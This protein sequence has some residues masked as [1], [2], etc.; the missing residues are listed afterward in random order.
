MAR[1]KA[2]Y[3]SVD[4][5]ELGRGKEKLAANSL[6][7][8]RG[9]KM[10]LTSVSCPERLGNVELHL[11]SRS[12][13]IPSYKIQNRKSTMEV[14]S[15][16]QS[17]LPSTGAP[18]MT[19]EKGM[20]LASTSIGKLPS[21][22]GEGHPN[23]REVKSEVLKDRS[24]RLGEQEGKEN[25]KSN[26]SINRI[27]IS[28][29]ELRKTLVTGKSSIT[30]LNNGIEHN[31]DE[32]A[33]SENLTKPLPEKENLV[34][35]RKIGRQEQTQ[36]RPLSVLEDESEAELVALS[37]AQQ[38]NQRKKS[39]K[40]SNSRKSKTPDGP[41][42]PQTMSNKSSVGSTAVPKVDWY[43]SRFT[44]RGQVGNHFLLLA[45]PGVKNETSVKIFHSNIRY[46]CIKHAER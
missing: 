25:I 34:R 42:S 15:Q 36:V 46:V 44:Q 16:R 10:T 38:N 41:N 26:G 8:T 40:I 11:H 32:V 20:G 33:S 7:L 3:G 13:K 18:T 27:G 23:V 12:Q 5:N 24:L 28:R 43:K 21:V 30:K 9:S 1:Y 2:I 17:R 37:P 14:K 45:M 29:G 6:R 39:R 4:E 19:R 31:A 22:M 35:Q